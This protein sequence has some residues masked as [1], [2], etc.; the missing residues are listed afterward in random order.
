MLSKTFAGILLSLLLTADFY[1]I[2]VTDSKGNEMSMRKFQGKKLL[3]L[4]ADP[5]TPIHRSLMQLDSLRKQQKGVEVLVVPV[6]ETMK[7]KASNWQASVDNAAYSKALHFTQ[8]LY[9]SRSEKG[10]QHPLF[11]WLSYQAEN[12][13]FNLE[14]ITAG[15]MFVISPTGVL[16]GILEK[17]T[18]VGVVA[19]VL[20]D[21]TVK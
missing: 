15:Q 12:G 20:A 17:N 5:L 13:H 1:S 3:I 11:R 6:S 16:Y 7:K 2:T 4:L 21:D 10:E 9:S 14:K 18:D 8:V 19:K